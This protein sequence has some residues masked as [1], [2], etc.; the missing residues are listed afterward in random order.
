VPCPAVVTIESGGTEPRYCAP[1]WVGRLRGLRV[2]LT[3]PAEI[4]APVDAAELRLAVLEVTPPRPR[5]KVGVRVAG[6]SL[7]D[8]LAVMRGGR[9]PQAAEE[10][11]VEGSPGEVAHR[12]KA[13]LERFLARPP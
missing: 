2:E 12:L 1:G 5:T 9:K 6:L 10:R 7:K 3:S 8:K 11:I 4:G 13:A